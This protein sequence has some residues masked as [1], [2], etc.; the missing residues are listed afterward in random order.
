M[1]LYLRRMLVDCGIEV[2]GLYYEVNGEGKCEVDGMSAKAK[3]GMLHRMSRVTTWRPPMPRLWQ[4]PSAV[5][6][7]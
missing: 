3:N 5:T 6:A 2:V 7:A 4:L 1:L